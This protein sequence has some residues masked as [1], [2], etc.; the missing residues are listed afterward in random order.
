MGLSSQLAPSAIARPG[1]IAN[2]AARPASPYDGQVIYQQ[3]IDGLLIWN[4]SAW[5]PP[6]NMPWGVVGYIKRTAGSYVAT[7]SFA[8]VTG[9]SVSFTAVANRAYRVTYSAL[10]GKTTSGGTAEFQITDG[11]NTK[12]YEM[13]EQM[14][15]NDYTIVTISAVVTGLA[16]G[17]QTLKVRAKTSVATTTVFATTDYPSSFIV[18]DIGPA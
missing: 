12:Q 3:D 17:S 14:A 5:Y 8:D 6:G 13:F 9:I 10:V 7:T 11:A 4:G 1:V 15:L 18:E 16:A 2:A